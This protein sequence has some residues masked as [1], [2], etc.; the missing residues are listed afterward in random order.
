MERL[1]AGDHVH[2]LCDSCL[3]VASSLCAAKSSGHHM[4][5]RFNARLI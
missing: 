4:L 5:H 3:L 1:D 2:D